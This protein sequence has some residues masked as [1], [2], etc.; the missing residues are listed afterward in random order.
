[1][2]RIAF[3]RRA[4]LAERSQLWL[5]I[6]TMIA[7]AAPTLLRYAIDRGANGVPFVTY[8][9]AI[10][11][12][13]L[14]LGWRHAAVVAIASGY[15]ARRLFLGGPTVL[16]MD[17]PNLV[18]TALY[19]LSCAVLI[20]TGETVRRTVRLL[21]VAAKNQQTLTEEMR[22]RVKNVLA[23]VQAIAVMTSRGNQ[24]DAWEAFSARLVALARATDLISEEEWKTCR[25]PDLVVEAT[26][27]FRA[28][29][30]IALDGPACCLPRECCIPAVLALHELC[31]NAVKHGALSVPGGTVTVRWRIEGETLLLQWREHGGPPV[32]P[33]T[34]KGLG[35]RLLVAQ[36]GLDD[37]D[38][39]FEPDGLQ[40][41]MR[42]E[43]AAHAPGD[44]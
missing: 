27:P 20:A 4:L 17:L 26:K 13:S 30:N 16:E 28:Y 36:N 18:F 11:V 37:V 22:H 1:M 9:P 25:M 21:E 38:L 42:I 10:M 40:C 24:P 31:T 8:F 2:T 14:F 34:R 41:A 23:V 33:P 6:W 39:R 5:A 3:V 32:A 19:A 15:V 7:V 44:G 35:T 29:G 43:G 12:A